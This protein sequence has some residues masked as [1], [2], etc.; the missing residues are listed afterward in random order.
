MVPLIRRLVLTG[1][2]A[3]SFGAP[4]LAGDEGF[5]RIVLAEDGSAA[6]LHAPG[7]ARLALLRDDRLHPAPDLGLVDIGRVFPLQGGW[8]GIGRNAR[9]A[10][11][12][13]HLD[14]DAGKV[15]GNVPVTNDDTADMDLRDGL[16]YL[17][18]ADGSRVTVVNVCLLLGSCTPAPGWP[19]RTEIDLLSAPPM[20]ILAD[21]VSNMAILLETS[22][23]V[24]AADL[25][26]GKVSLRVVAPPG[27]G[28]VEIA[29][30]AGPSGE[31]VAYLSLTTDQIVQVWQPDSDFREL[32]Q[33]G[34]IALAE[35]A[36]SEAPYVV[37][38]AP[39]IP[40]TA[41]GAQAVARVAASDDRK[42][43]LIAGTEPGVVHAL[44]QSGRA[45]SRRL[46]IRAAAQVI[47]LDVAA[48][49]NAVALL[50][51]QGAIILDRNVLLNRTSALEVRDR[52]TSA[53]NESLLTSAIQRRLVA[54]G[55]LPSLVDGILGT[56]TR[57]A[58]DRYAT[59]YDLPRSGRA[60]AASDLSPQLLA[61]LFQGHLSELPAA[62]VASPQ[63]DAVMRASF[64]SFWS[65]N[66]TGIRHF[67]PDEVYQRGQAPGCAPLNT[68]AAA[69]DWPNIIAPLLALDGL[70]GTMGV[71]I[72]IEAT[73][74]SPAYAQ[75]AATPVALRPAAAQFR[76]ITFRLPRPPADVLS[77]FPVTPGLAL[78]HEG[79]VFHLTA[80]PAPA[81]ADIEQLGQFHALIASYPTDSGECRHAI[82]NVAEFHRLLSGS[83]A[84][85]LPIYVARTQVSGHYAVTVDTGQDRALARQVS[86]TIRAV[87]S[88]SAD[89][90]TGADSYVQINR[91]WTIDPACD[92]G[93]IIP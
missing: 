16:A 21:P 88:Q 63:G 44:D 89:H 57:E 90:R 82:A 59:R 77:A 4:A 42:L 81:S 28:P 78:D 20:R 27:P 32:R 54:E 29:L 23:A 86:D 34:V 38:A 68:A 79:G 45:A 92:A 72:M 80:D 93:A 35:L 91:N 2:L 13:F 83:Q 39:V 14:A 24:V 7:T 19:E 55:F 3:L 8:V 73:M 30:S 10:T 69:T 6:L 46:D 52:D 66:M 1:F 5:D 47:D 18:S 37:A 67:R 75:C 26:G 15:L 33:S 43:V 62:F 87:A 12:L 60:G 85:G 84:S 40:V 49:G 64:A 36:G 76:V 65:L 48:S 50:T 25:L 61:R 51:T 9:G 56:S 53:R 58:L 11:R 22:G 31:A 74:Q 71:P 17:A 41:V 70:R